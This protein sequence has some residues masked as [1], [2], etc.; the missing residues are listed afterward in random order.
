MAKASTGGKPPSK[1]PAK[2]T[3]RQTSPRVSTISAKVMNGYKPTRAELLAIA[4][5]NMSQ[6]Q[7]RGQKPKPK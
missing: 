3:P 5:S 2:P 7:T 6:D 1:P 4:A